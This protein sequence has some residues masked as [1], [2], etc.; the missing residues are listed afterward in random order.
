MKDTILAARL[1]CD[2]VNVWEL[3]G[4][5]I[6]TP[7]EISNSHLHTINILH[8]INI[9]TFPKLHNCHKRPYSGPNETKRNSFRRRIVRLSWMEYQICS[10]KD[11]IFTCIPYCPHTT[12]I[13]NTI[14][15]TLHIS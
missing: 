2:D 11:D 1:I 14:Q 7:A 4:E 9:L 12:T 13:T 6:S 5:Y 3:R 10:K 8:I 15:S